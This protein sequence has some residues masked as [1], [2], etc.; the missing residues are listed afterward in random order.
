M[1]K[2]KAGE[3]VYLT[4]PFRPDWTIGE[5]VSSLGSYI[6]VRRLN[7]GHGFGKWE[8][9]GFLKRDAFKIKNLSPLQRA[10][11]VEDYE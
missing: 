4:D 7:R 6:S 2:F 11:L 8:V 9:A 10:L 3:L 1:S 5:I